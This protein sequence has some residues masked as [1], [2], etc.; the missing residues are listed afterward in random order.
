MKVRVKEGKWGFYGGVK[1]NSY[2]GKRPPDE[3]VLVARKHST[4]MKAGKPVVISV[5]QQ[6]S[7][8]WMEDITPAVKAEAPVAPRS[9]SGR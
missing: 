8:E 9:N 4:Q 5:K 2:G 7:S 6:F 1:R 3:F